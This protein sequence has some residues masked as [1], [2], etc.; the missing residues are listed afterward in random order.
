ME[1]TYYNF[2]NIGVESTEQELINIFKHK[3]Y[4]FYMNL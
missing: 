4:S 2:S 1:S 3:V